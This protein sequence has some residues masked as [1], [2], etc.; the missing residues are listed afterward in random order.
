VSGERPINWNSTC[1]SLTRI[2]PKIMRKEP[3]RPVFTSILPS[4][5][6]GTVTV[7]LFRHFDVNTSQ[8]PSS[9]TFAQSAN[10]IKLA[11]KAPPGCGG[12]TV[13]SQDPLDR[14]RVCRL[15]LTNT[16][17][18]RQFAG[19]PD[20]LLY[21]HSL[22]Y[23]GFLLPGFGLREHCFPGQFFQCLQYGP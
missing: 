6:G 10:I 17:P 16:Q 19:K 1:C 4:N 21:H 2:L 7:S 12:G 22:S 5:N 14:T 15:R 11:S 9:V 23:E 20:L 18:G 3:F 8:Q 13:I